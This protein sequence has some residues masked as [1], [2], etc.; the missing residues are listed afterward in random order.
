RTGMETEELLSAVRSKLES[1]GVEEE[2]QPER[3]RPVAL[4]SRVRR[5]LSNLEG[6]LQR[7]LEAIK[8]DP[9]VPELILKLANIHLKE[10]NFARAIFLYEI[11][12]GMN[13]DQLSGWIHMGLAYL[14]GG[15]PKEAV[16]CFGSALAI[17]PNS[18]DALVYMA[19]AQLDL[20]DL[21]VCWKNLEAAVRINPDSGRAL[22][23]KGLYFEKQGNLR[24]A[25]S[26]VQNALSIEPSFLPALME[27]GRLHLMQKQYDMAT[28]VLERALRMDH[29]QPYALSLFGDVYFQVG[30][31]VQA[32]HYY[33]RAVSVKFDDPIIWI[34][35]GDTHKIM[36]SFKEA[37]DAYHK[38]IN[39]D[40]ESIEAWVKCG[41][42]ML[43]MGDSGTALEY[44]N[45]ALALEPSNADVAHK[46]GRLHFSL[47]KLEEALADFDSAFSTDIENPEHL[48]Y[49]ALIL[50]KLDRNIEARR[51]WHVAAS[52]YQEMG[53]ET[54]SAE[55]TARAKRLG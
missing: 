35:K 18:V 21:E 47:N 32:L 11:T 33:D 37:S 28:M 38:A 23:V 20:D 46:R 44:F 8:Y 3:I 26:W 52:L 5:E 40:P 4:H 49:R 15:Y 41:G 34:K 7:S 43:L 2:I 45:T 42:V 29:E 12:L 50:E 1:I 25:V 10:S 17:E 55:C 27:L 22:L 13:S 14:K 36:K 30:E 9:R 51:T 31:Y 39:A 6:E 48:Y 54:K 19:S 53:N 24:G 16:S